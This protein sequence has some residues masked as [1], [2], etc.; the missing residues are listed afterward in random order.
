VDF[1]TNDTLDLVIKRITT[2]DGK[3]MAKWEV[4]ERLDEVI[5]EIDNK[6]SEKLNINDFNE[7]LKDYDN[8][9]QE[10]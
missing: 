8:E 3:F 4:N 2:Q 10:K 1:V 9:V 7:A 6:I 5:K